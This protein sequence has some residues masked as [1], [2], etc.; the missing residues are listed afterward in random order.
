MAYTGTF[1]TSPI[2]V[3][4]DSRLLILEED[5]VSLATQYN[6]IADI[7]AITGYENGDRAFCLENRR[8]YKYN[9]SSDLIDNGTTILRPDDKDSGQTGRWEE[10]VLLAPA[11]HTHSSLQP[12]PDSFVQGNF[13][14]F[15]SDGKLIDSAKKPADFVQDASYVHTDNNYNDTAKGKV[16][17]LP[18]NTN[19]ELDKKANKV[20]GMTT[21]DVGKICIINADG[22]YSIYSKTPEEIESGYSLII[23]AQTTLADFITNEWSTAALETGDW[24]EITDANGYVHYYMLYQNDGD[25]ATDY[26]EFAK[27][28]YIP[29]SQKGAA[30][31]VAT[32]N[33]SQKLTAAQI[34]DNMYTSVTVSAQ[35]TLSGYINNEWSDGS[36]SLGDLIEI[37]DADGYLY[38]YI[39]FQNNGSATAD[40]KLLSHM[41]FIGIAQKGAANG[42]AE[43]DASA[44]VP[45]SQLP[46][47]VKESKVVADIAARDALTPYESLRVHVIDATADSTVDN[48]GAGYIYDGTSWVKT[49]EEEGLDAAID[50]SNIANKPT[51]SVTNIDDAATKKH[52]QGT[53]QALDTGGANEVTATQAKSAYEHS[54]T[55]HAP[56]SAEENVQSN[57]NQADT[58]AD[59]YI[60]NK[61]SDLTDL[62]THSANE[63]ND[64][65]TAG[66]GKTL[67]R[68]A[69]AYLA[70]QVEG[71]ETLSGTTIDLSASYQ[72]IE[73]DCAGADITL[74]FSALKTGVMRI[75]TLSNCNSLAFSGVT[76]SLKGDTIGGAKDRLMIHCVNDASESE[77][78]IA[79][80][81]DIS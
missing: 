39:L 5:G 55:T 12:I 66:E 50:W 62:S 45:I 58:G 13:P 53:D 20:T 77:E 48:N 64:V 69:S 38:Y 30:D 36:I 23:S 67:I 59:D 17:N 54:Q 10:D 46:D 18:T 37:T 49:Y 68:G 24:I 32:L 79:I 41:K 70:K 3:D 74:D 75:V 14:A 51:S 34:P 56:A 42:V 47:V 35:N 27:N 25:E 8:I 52:T 61:P 9:S 19:T 15:D 6:T 31:G 2:I 57:W 7:R 16:A 63:M 60:K 33:A 44:L 26:K 78:I 28:S 43:L 80:N 73:K 1:G 11:N 22:S 71:K 72:D 81:Q 40:Y 4:I 76:S 65:P 21:G 29:V